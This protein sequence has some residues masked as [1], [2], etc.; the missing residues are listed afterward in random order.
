M[1]LRHAADYR[2]ADEAPLHPALKPASSSPRARTF[3][4]SARSAHPESLRNRASQKVA[5]VSWL[6]EVV[7]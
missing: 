4:A 7:A 3:M 2:G 5:A 6:S 1:T